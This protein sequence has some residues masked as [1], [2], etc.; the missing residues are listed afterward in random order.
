MDFLRFYVRFDT[1]ALRANFEKS[2]ETLTKGDNT[3]G[4]EEQLLE[5]AKEEGI[6]IG[7]EKG[8]EIG[9]EEG[10]LENTREIV[11]E[12]RGQGFQ[13]DMIEKITGLSSGDLAK[14]D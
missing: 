7:K 4:I 13:N 1:P 10:R 14:I 12:M 9:K 6:E 8:I 2:I 11:R 3:M 5:L